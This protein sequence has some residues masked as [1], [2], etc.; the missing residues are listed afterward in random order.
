MSIA[1]P[2]KKDNLLFASGIGD[3]G[4]II[5]LDDSAKPDA[6]IVWRGNPKNSVYAANVTPII[7]GD[8]IYGCDCEQGALMAVRMSDGKRLWETREPTTR[9]ERRARHGTAFLVKHEDRYF[10]FSETGDLILARLSPEGYEEI[11]RQHILE[12]T[13]ECFGRDVV[14]SHPAFADRAVFA[15][16]DKELVAVSLAAE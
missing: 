13:N 8:V 12:P 7:D 16:N 15:R 14:W 1:I 4:A 3:V 5:Q 6:K 11:S 9:T 2:R 10:L